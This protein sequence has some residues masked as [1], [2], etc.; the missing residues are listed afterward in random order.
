MVDASTQYDDADIHYAAPPLAKTRTTMKPKEPSHPPPPKN[1]T[2]LGV[3]RVSKPKQPKGPPPKHLIQV[4]MRLQEKC[5]PTHPPARL[6]VSKASLKKPLQ[7]LS[8]EE[9]RQLEATSAAAFAEYFASQP[10]VLLR[11]PGM[12]AMVPPDYGKGKRGG[13]GGGG[14]NKRKHVDDSSSDMN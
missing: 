10:S 8:D 3:T 7:P 14:G 1:S 2:H 6:V 4:P 9:K 13:G 11:P 5:A 12:P